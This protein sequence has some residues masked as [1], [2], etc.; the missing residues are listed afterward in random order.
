VS[1]TATAR[2]YTERR[3]IPTI[4]E[5]N[6]VVRQ[7]EDDGWVCEAGGSKRYGYRVTGWKGQE[8]DIIRTTIGIGTGDSSV[9][10][11]YRRADG[12]GWEYADGTPAE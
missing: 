2:D 8:P 3:N 1:D 11:L 7:M 10:P 6:A 5:R 12:S 9:T 4:K